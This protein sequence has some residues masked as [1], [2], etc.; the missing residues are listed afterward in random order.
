MAALSTL[1]INLQYKITLNNSTAVDNLD[2]E[3]KVAIAWSTLGLVIY[4]N[5]V[6]RYTSTSSAYAN[7]YST[8]ELTRVDRRPRVD[9]KQIL[10][11]KTRLSNEELA[12]LT[13]I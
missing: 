6:S 13:T 2:G 4:I 1:C 5:G 7:P 9:M 8:F 12:A 11:F 10:F 3:A